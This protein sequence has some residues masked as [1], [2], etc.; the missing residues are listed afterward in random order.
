[1]V[2]N[3]NRDLLSEIIRETL[4][5][6][7]KQ[8]II[9]TPF[10]YYKTF[11][12][13]AIEHGLSE[14]EIHRYVYDT[15][16]YVSS[17]ELEQM[18][19][20]TLEIAKNI[21][22]TAET[23]QQSVEKSD[24]AYKEVIETLTGCKDRVA[25]EIGNEIEKILYISATLKSELDAARRTLEKQREELKRLKE[26]SFKDQLTGLYT[27][28][29]MEEAL[30]TVL[31]NF[32]RY[33]RPCSIIMLDL[34][35]F[36]K[37]NDTYGHLAGDTVLKTV[38]SVVQ[39][40]IRRSDI[41]VRYGGDEFIVILPDTMLEDAVTVGEKIANKVQTIKFD[42]NGTN[43]KC[44]IS[45]GVTHIKEGDTIE[46]LLERVDQALYETK[47]KGKKGITVIE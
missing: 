23:M 36:K 28:K 30:N 46:T 26:F 21:E 5:R 7:T 1:L 44:T 2:N 6:A 43:F 3:N 40:I 16:F 37:I 19:K 4:F 41:P 8:G 18:K 27:R 17:E 31:Y 15:D 32:N 45:V 33:S 9:L 22:N 14:A 35:D 29:Y 38:A 11:T 42:K 20:K 39:R 10:N 25:E 13:V 34:D 47:D 12:E 24:D